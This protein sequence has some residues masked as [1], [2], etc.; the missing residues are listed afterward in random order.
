MLYAIGIGM[1]RNLYDERRV[2]RPCLAQNDEISR[3]DAHQPPEHGRVPGTVNSTIEKRCSWQLCVE[4]K[5]LGQRYV[6][7]SKPQSHDATLGATEPVGLC[8]KLQ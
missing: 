5:R 1:S 8:L 7:R 3:S 2:K 4:P 6:L